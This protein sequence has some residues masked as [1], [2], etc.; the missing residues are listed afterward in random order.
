MM[1]GLGGLRNPLM[2]CFLCSGARGCRWL[3]GPMLPQVGGDF[4]CLAG[5]GRTLTHGT[6][7]SRA[8]ARKTLMRSSLGRKRKNS[9]GAGGA[10]W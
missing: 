5:A 3:A 6:A 7:T 4:L 8:S 9:D 1:L 10:M 2:A